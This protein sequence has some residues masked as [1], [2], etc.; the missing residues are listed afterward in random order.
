MP[1]QR[2][3]RYAP[4]EKASSATPVPSAADKV[5]T[6]VAL[7]S[8]EGCKNREC[9][10]TT[11][12]N[13]VTTPDKIEDF[14]VVNGATRYYEKQGSGPAILFIAGSTGDVT[15]L[16]QP[17]YWP[18]SLLSLRT[19][20]VATPE[21][22]ARRGGPQLRSPNKLMTPQNS[23]SHLASRLPWSSVAAREA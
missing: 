1:R 17:P 21:A 8:M 19:I 5:D 13:V 10:F 14:A 7:A 20:R 15:S 11:G 6:T 4:I 9:P 2:R 3:G 18:M 22:R 12:M 23:F 16:G